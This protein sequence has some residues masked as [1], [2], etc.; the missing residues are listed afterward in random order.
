MKSFKNFLNQNNIQEGLKLGSSKINTIPKY[1]EFPK[2]KQELIMLLYD[3]IQ[4]DPNADLNDID[5]SAIT[6]MENLFKEMEPHNIKLDLWDV[7]KVTSMGGMFSFSDDFDADLSG[8]DVSNVE[9]F[10]WMFMGCQEFKGKGLKNWNTRR[11][12]NFR[13]MFSGCHSFNE[14]VS[15]WNVH[16][17]RDLSMMFNYCKSFNQDLSDWDVSNCNTFIDMFRLS[18]FDYDLTKWNVQPR[19]HG[20]KV[21]VD[22]MFYK[23]PA[24]DHAPEWYENLA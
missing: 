5:V 4:D 12:E 21:T 7:S 11:G 24:K 17:A 15:G 13:A 10:S 8:W 3:R 1:T 20:Y 6:D 2:T 19:V 22:D 23:C 14:D 16:N 9:D 18:A